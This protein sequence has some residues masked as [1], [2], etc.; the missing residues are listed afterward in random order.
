MRTILLIAA[1]PILSLSLLLG[2]FGRGQDRPAQTDSRAIDPEEYAVY[3]ALIDQ[4]YI[5]P[6]TRG[7]FSLS[8]TVIDSFG[9]DKIEQVVILPQTLFTLE[10]FISGKNLREMLPA[11]AQA[12]ATYP[13]A[14]VTASEHAVQADTFVQFVLG[15]MAQS[16]LGAAGFGPPS[17]A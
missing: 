6:S 8:G 16:I 5:H 14:V 13:V 1:S 4:K 2:L 9:P 3:S 11:E 7:G 12:V 10:Q 15:P 17:G